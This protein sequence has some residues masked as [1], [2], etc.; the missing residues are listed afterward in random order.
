MD[1]SSIV[2]VE[3]AIVEEEREKTLKIP[4]NSYQVDKGRYRMRTSR[5]SQRW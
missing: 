5:Q 1:G 3:E 4:T 2:A